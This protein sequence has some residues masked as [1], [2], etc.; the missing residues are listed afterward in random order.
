MSSCRG[1]GTA[2]GRDVSNEGPATVTVG[3]DEVGARWTEL[4]TIVAGAGLSPGATAPTPGVIIVDVG[5]VSQPA[6]DFTGTCG[7]SR[8]SGAP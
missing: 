2:A 6:P 1:L 8:K 4:L 3:V 5:V 7:S